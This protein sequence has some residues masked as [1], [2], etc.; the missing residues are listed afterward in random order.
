[1]IYSMFAGPTPDSARR[2]GRREGGQDLPR[3]LVV[4]PLGQNGP[5]AE[6]GRLE[7]LLLE[8]DRAQIPVLLQERAAALFDRAEEI[9]LRPVELAPRQVKDSA[10]ECIHRIALAGEDTVQPS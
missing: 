3:D 2:A 10:I 1:G 4:R 7:L 5:V 6:S 9:P 8:K